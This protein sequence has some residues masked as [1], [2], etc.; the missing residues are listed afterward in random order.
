MAARH[1]SKVG[2]AVLL[3]VLFDFACEPLLSLWL[4]LRESVG[5]R[6]VSLSVGSPDFIA[7]FLAACIAVFARILAK[8]SELDAENRRFV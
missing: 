5:H 1:L 7:L 3:W 4:T 6:V 8:A 2:Y